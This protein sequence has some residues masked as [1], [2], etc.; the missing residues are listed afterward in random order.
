MANCE[1]HNQMVAMPSFEVF[2]DVW[3]LP[4]IKTKT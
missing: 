3:D 2:G 1:R 4:D